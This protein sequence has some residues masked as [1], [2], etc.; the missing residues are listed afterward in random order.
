MQFVFA[1]GEINWREISSRGLSIHR[2]REGSDN[3]GTLMFLFHKLQDNEVPPTLF[4]FADPMLENGDLFFHLA[5][6][7]MRDCHAWFVKEVHDGSGQAADQNDEKTERANENR[8]GLWHPAE[9]M[10]HDLQ[11]LF[12][13]TDSGEAD[14]QRRDGTLDRH[15]GKEIDQRHGSAQGVSGA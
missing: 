5:Q 9:T 14:W 15:D 1:R 8:C 13:K 2:H 7:H 3:E 4:R 6:F 12:P 11:N 10:Q